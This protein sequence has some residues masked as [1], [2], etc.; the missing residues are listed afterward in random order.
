MYQVLARKWRPQTFEELVGQRHVAKTLSNAIQ[1]QRLAHAYLFSGLR[2]SGKTTVARILAK[3]LNCEQGPT[4]TPCNECVPCR[5]ITESRAIDVLEVDAAS[6]TKVDQTRELLEVV[7]YAPARDRNK[8]LIIDEAHM[9]SKSSF[10]ALLKT[11]EEPPPNVIFILATT[12]MQKILPTIL[13]RC[14]VFEFR[15]VPVREL[16]P[17]LRRIC[18]SEGITISD[19][20]LERIARAGDGS[21][22]DALS[23]LERV[24]AFCGE[25]VE[26]EEVMRLLGAVSAEVLA[27]LVGGLAQRDA[28]AM[29]RTLDRVNDEGHDLLH[30]W[31]ELIAALRDLL[32]MDALPGEHDLL[33]RSPEDAAALEQA[34]SGLSREDLTRAFHLLAEL[35]PALRSTSRPRFLFEAA[36]LRLASLGHVRAIEEVLSSLGGAPPSGSSTSGGPAPESKAPRKKTTERTSAP[37]TATR[38][39]QE[40]REATG[41]SAQLIDAIQDAKPMLGAVLEQAA[42]VSLDGGVLS[43][44]FDAGHA[45]LAQTLQRKESLAQLMKHAGALAGQTVEVQIEVASAAPAPRP[46][47]QKEPK[48]KKKTAPRQD[49]PRK[50]A[51][52]PNGPGGDLLSQARKDPGVK[53]L[54]KEFGAQVVEIR[55]LEAGSSPALGE[56]DGLVEDPK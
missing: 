30:F 5:E 6:R 45:A 3:C 37:P 19:S 2:G 38:E 33:T 52:E 51:P 29:L 44:A 23:V 26:D 39:P 17:H 40:P 34:A 41:L 49:N 50:S 27:S 7:S 20:A 16:G 25:S 28:A 4:P 47:A 18:D 22:R 11:L 10:N 14:Q 56:D 53:K 43:L 8:I 31:S 36:L 32:M 9:L 54:L 1:T 35:E 24:L 55:P 21:V 48:E 15:R 13:S 42:S 46:A 12:E